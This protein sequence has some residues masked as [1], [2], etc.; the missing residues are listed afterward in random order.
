MNKQTNFNDLESYGIW[1]GIFDYLQCLQTP[2]CDL[3]QNAD[4]CKQYAIKEGYT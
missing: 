3:C 1:T 2:E 4:L